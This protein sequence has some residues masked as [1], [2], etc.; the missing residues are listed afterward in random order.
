VFKGRCRD[1]DSSTPSRSL[2]CEAPPLV[3]LLKTQEAN[4][5]QNADSPIAATDAAA[6]AVLETAPEPIEVQEPTQQ[7]QISAM[8]LPPTPEEGSVRR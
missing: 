6:A 2:H 8:E 5:P 1:I 4:K 3:P 7:M